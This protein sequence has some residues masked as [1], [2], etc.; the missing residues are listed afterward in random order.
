MIAIRKAAGEPSP[1]TNGIEA[2]TQATSTSAQ[3]TWASPKTGSQVTKKG[4]F[5]V[6][7]PAPAPLAIRPQATVARATALSASAVPVP[8]S[9]RK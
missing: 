8:G 1:R 9:R 6:P 7:S 3:R 2:A 4:G 5:A